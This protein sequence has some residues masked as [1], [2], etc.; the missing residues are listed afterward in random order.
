MFNL[1][2]FLPVFCPHQNDC[3]LT[4]NLIPWSEYFLGHIHCWDLYFPF[5]KCDKDDRKAQSSC[6][7]ITT[8]LMNDECSISYFSTVNHGH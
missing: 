2:C 6:Y 8:I 4:Y 1:R 5:D 7:F 3:L